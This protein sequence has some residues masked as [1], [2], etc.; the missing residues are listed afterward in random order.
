MRRVNAHWPLLLLLGVTLGLCG[1]GPAI[2]ARS[3]D[4][5]A[6]FGVAAFRLHP[7][8]TQIKS[9][10]GKAKADGIE[11]VI[12]FDDQFGD[13]TRAAGQVRFEL[14]KFLFDSPDHRGQ[15]LAIWAT[16]LSGKDDQM[17]HWDPAARAY[18]FQLNFDKISTEHSY[19]LTAQYDRDATR[20]FSQLVIEPSE[21]E[22]FHGDRRTQHAPLNGPG[23]GGI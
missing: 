10:T 16:S 22:G 15:R 5:Q 13:P 8:F 14:Y 3:A 1:C 6:M 4:E 20:L 17:A 2:I 9:W 12:E 11:A 23:H 7:T 18:S 19:V 21:K